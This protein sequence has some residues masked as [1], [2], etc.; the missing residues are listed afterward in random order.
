MEGQFKAEVRLGS[1]E[2]ASPS[3]LEALGE[4]Q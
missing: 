3:T 2:D 1:T 4:E